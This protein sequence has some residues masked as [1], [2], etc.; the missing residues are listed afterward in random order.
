MLAKKI[1]YKQYL[2]GQKRLIQ[3]LIAEDTNVHP[4]GFISGK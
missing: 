4:K 1:R 3:G 2:K